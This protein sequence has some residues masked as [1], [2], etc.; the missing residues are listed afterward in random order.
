MSN[1]AIAKAMGVT[2]PT[3]AEDIDASTC[4]NF[5]VDDQADTVD[6]TIATA[7]GTDSETV[8]R[9]IKAAAGNP[10][11]D[12]EPPAGSPN[13][14]PWYRDRLDTISHQLFYS[15]SITVNHVWTHKV[16]PKRV[17]A[18]PQTPRTRPAPPSR[19]HMFCQQ[20]NSTC[21]P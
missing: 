10:A 1:A 20:T 11:A 17:H 7:V 21:H 9:D 16:C 6:R 8:N 18:L 3:V 15:Y 14:N 13:P 19:A 5:H 4:R 2:H 12:H